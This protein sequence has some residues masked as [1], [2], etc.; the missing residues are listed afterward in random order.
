MRRKYKKRKRPFHGVQKETL[1]KFLPSILAVAFLLAVRLSVF[2]LSEAGSPKSPQSA[3]KGVID[4]YD[5]TARTIKG[6]DY[7][8]INTILSDFCEGY[9]TLR[10]DLS[11]IS[12]LT[13]EETASYA[14]YNGAHPDVMR[15]KIGS[16]EAGLNNALRDEELAAHLDSLYTD[17]NRS[18]YEDNIVVDMYCNAS[19]ILVN[20]DLLSLLGVTSDIYDGSPDSFVQLLSEIKAKNTE[21]EYITFDYI[22]EDIY[23]YLPFL[24]YKGVEE[25]QEEYLDILRSFLP[26]DSSERSAD[27]VRSDFYGG[28]SVVCVLSLS[29]VNYML[30]RQM[31]QKGFDFDI[32]KYPTEGKDFVFIRETV[33]YIFYDSGNAAKNAV[34]KDLA[35]YMLSDEA[36]KY[37]EN[38]GMLPCGKIKLVYDT[39]PHLKAFTENSVEYF[40]HRDEGIKKI[41]ETLDNN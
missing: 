40:T 18:V 28:K 26:S 1:K 7:S 14:F 38:I 10:I 31:N 32:L 9:D 24:L 27:T 22:D 37:T 36:Q 29:E 23:S 15:S 8:F 17:R 2:M 3:Y 25:P 6:N 30:R 5:T 12:R 41:Y 4:F 21:G 33:S 13:P 20:N 34:L 19:V 35:L 39:Y 11:R 16:F